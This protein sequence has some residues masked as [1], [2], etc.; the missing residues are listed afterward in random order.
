MESKV[1]E[2]QELYSKFEYVVNCEEKYEELVRRLEEETERQKKYQKEY[3]YTNTDVVI[4]NME[5]YIDNAIK[6]KKLELQKEVQTQMKEISDVN[7]KISKNFQKVTKWLTEEK[8][9]KI[10]TQNELDY[11]QMTGKNNVNNNVIFDIF[12][13]I[14]RI[15]G[16]VFRFDFLTF[17][18][19]VLRILTAI[20]VWGVIISR[21]IVMIV[22]DRFLQKYEDYILG[23]R[24]EEY[25]KALEVFK[26]DV[27]QA[28]TIRIVLAI[29]IIVIINFI[30]Y[31][32]TKY[33][34]KNYILKNQL[35]YMANINPEGI[36][37]A[38]YDY[39]FMEFMKGTVSNW[40]NEIKNI[41][42]FGLKIEEKNSEKIESISSAIGEQ[43]KHKYEELSLEISEKENEIEEYI[44]KAEIATKNKEEFIAELKSK[45]NEVIGMIGDGEYNKRVLSPWVAL[46]FSNNK[47]HG[48]KELIAFKHNYK[49]M[50]VCY[51]EESSQNEEQ[52]RKNIPILIEKFMKGFFSENSIDIISMWLVDFEG[53]HFPESRTHG[54][55]KVLKTQR[56][57]QDLYSKLK[58]IR[59]KV[60]SL[61]DGKIESINPDKLRKSENPIK[62]N[63]IFF[64]GVDFTSLDREIVQLFIEGE[65]FGFL[66]ILFMKKNTARDLLM[67]K[68]TR[69]FF[70]VVKKIKE[71]KQIYGYEGIIQ[72]FEYELIVSNQ[73]KE[74][75]EKLYSDKILSFEEFEDIAFS[76][77]GISVEKNLYVDTYNIPRELYETL[78]QYEF[79]EF[80]TTN[81][82]TP[83]FVNKDVI[84]V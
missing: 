36:A 43:L 46:G 5:S 67:E 64:V 10:I 13:F 15:F 39:K 70:K 73:K 1:Q 51:N 53:L 57:L 52:L 68:N 79:V 7:N 8:V 34:A 63:I 35:I 42:N 71:S 83:D 69:D 56:E 25:E 21:E 55:M 78:S 18:P 50:L 72:E 11:N 33:Y 77:E 6:E 23:L 16:F 30:I 14:N 49:P 2:Y 47:N 44:T 17:F 37:K 32:I 12:S 75:S 65:N 76:G 26:K 41:K 24:D 38:L 48:A 81:G 4:K 22:Y 27:L 66:P 3:D 54:L 60:N 82:I 40:E 29:G 31:Y 61:L 80:F 20:I 28:S 74:L 59:D 45:E 84:N 19:K 58:D 62:Y 9:N